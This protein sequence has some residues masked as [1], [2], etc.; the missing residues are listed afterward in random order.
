M[1]VF[2]EHPIQTGRDVH[3][4]SLMREDSIKNKQK[5]NPNEIIKM[6]YRRATTGC[7]LLY[8]KNTWNEQKLKSIKQNKLHRQGWGRMLTKSL[9]WLL[10]LK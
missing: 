9:G 4:H 3:L 2:E 1:S 6:I 10:A 5:N 7:K 8:T